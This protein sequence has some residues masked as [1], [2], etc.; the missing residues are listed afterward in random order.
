MFKFCLWYRILKN[1]MLNSTVSK[2]SDLF[3]TPIFV[4]HITFRHSMDKNTADIEYINNKKHPNY[5][6]KPYGRP[7]Q[8]SFD[9]FHAIQQN[10]S[11]QG[12]SYH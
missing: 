12:Y 3:N 7:Y 4:P 5:I 11:V 9:G 1:N 6:F 10:V 2:Y 8:T